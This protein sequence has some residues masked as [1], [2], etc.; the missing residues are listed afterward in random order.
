[1]SLTEFNHVFFAVFRYLAEKYLEQINDVEEEEQ[2]LPKSIGT[3]KLITL[4]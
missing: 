4:F 2:Y 3:S 1:M